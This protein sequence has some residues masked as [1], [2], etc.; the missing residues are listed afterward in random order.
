[1]NVFNVEGVNDS[2]FQPQNKI[3]NI[4]VLKADYERLLVSFSETQFKIDLE[5][6]IYL[7]EMR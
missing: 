6:C 1:M 3:K 5:S 2:D 4:E 7:I